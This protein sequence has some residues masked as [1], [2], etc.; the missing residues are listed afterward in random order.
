MGKLAAFLGATVGGASGGWLGAKYGTMTGFF[1]SV[2]GTGIGIYLGKRW[3]D[4][5]L[6]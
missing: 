6:P 2:L 1:L 4:Q 3:G 5:Y